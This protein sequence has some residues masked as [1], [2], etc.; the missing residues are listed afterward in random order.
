MFG[1]AIHGGAGTL[2]RAEMTAN[3]SSNTAMDSNGAR[4]GAT[5]W[6]EAARVSMR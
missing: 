3:A 4:L 1:I 5:C 6:S 2:P